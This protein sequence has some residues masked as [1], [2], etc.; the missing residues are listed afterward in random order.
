M[1]PLNMKRKMIFYDV[2]QNGHLKG[3]ICLLVKLTV[4]FI[5]YF[6]SYNIILYIMSDISKGNTCRDSTV[7]FM[8]LSER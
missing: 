5:Y 6:P 2:I 4:L 1:N 7:D 8:D 3:F